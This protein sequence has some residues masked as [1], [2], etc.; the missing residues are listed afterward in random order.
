MEIIRTNQ[1]AQYSI[2]L[3][4]NEPL[5]VIDHMN[6]FDINLKCPV[7]T[8]INILSPQG[9]EVFCEYIPNSAMAAA[10]P[11]LDI[12]F[13][14]N[15]WFEENWISR[16]HPRL[17]ANKQVT[18]F[19][20]SFNNSSHVGRILL[21]A[22]LNNNGYFDPETCSKNFSYEPSIVLG[23]LF[24]L[25]GERA[26]WYKWFFFKNDLEHLAI[27]KE[28]YLFGHVD[29]DHARNQEFIASK[30]DKC[31]LHLV[32]ETMATSYYPFVTEKFFY[33]VAAGG[34]FLA[35]AQPG[36]HEHVTRWLGFRKYTRIFDYRFDRIQNP[37]VRLIALM[38][39]ISKFSKLSVYQWNELY[40]VEQ[41]NIDYNYEHFV[42]GRY[43]THLHKKIAKTQS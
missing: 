42:S 10:Y 25:I 29:Q 7:L 19:L 15:T 37:V 6:G 43:L 41:E 34:L 23:Y 27:A 1:K 11:R 20:C 12:K 26:N 36:W 22:A 16:I 3:D 30:I 32:S 28:K 39:M 18:H 2:E 21:T 31:F 9:R 40:Q 17:N 14:A 8:R 4:H 38:D 24:D 5:T 35:Y 33:S 13:D